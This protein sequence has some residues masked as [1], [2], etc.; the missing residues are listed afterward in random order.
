MKKII[1]PWQC[2]TNVR[3]FTTTRVGGVSLSPFNSFNLATH[4]GDKQNSV[5]TNRTL[6]VQQGQLP[7]MPVF[8]QQVHSTK[9]ITLPDDLSAN[10]P[11]AD[12]VYT[13]Q[14]NQVCLVMTADCLP[15]LLVNQQG[16][17]V[18]AVHAG[19][20]GLCEGIL[21]ATLAKFRSN[22]NQILAWLGP[23]ISQ[24]AFQVGEEVRQQFVERDPQATLAFVQDKSAVGNQNKFLADL[25]L[26][27]KQRLNAFGVSNITGGEYCTYRQAE[28]F[29][30]YRREQQ[31]GRMASLIWF[32]AA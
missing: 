4:V 7:H 23:A 20:R 31:T 24:S 12:A 27:A 18:A 2:P 1:P 22:P 28:D 9:V 19:W 8:L 29:F 10:I 26:L 15:V 14:P 5:E 3:A 13:C 16:N 25:Y 30:S 32:E 21:E 17:E 6:L 11:I